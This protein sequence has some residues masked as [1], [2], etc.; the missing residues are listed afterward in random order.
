MRR[1][2]PVVVIGLDLGDGRLLER[3]GR[4]GALPHVR[5]LLDAGVATRLST[6]AEVLHVSA[7]PSLYTGA[8]PGEHGVY[9]TFQPRPGAQGHRRFETGLYGRPTVWRLLDRAGVRCSVLDAP[10]THPEPGDVA[11]VFDWGV[12]AQYLGPRSAPRTLLRRLRAAVGPYRLGLEAHDIGLAALD[13][14]EMSGR[15]AAAAGQKAEAALWTMRERPWDLFFVVFGETHPAA[16]YCWPSGADVDAAARASD[17]RSV[18]DAIDRGIGRIVE[19]APAD[20][21][22]CLVSADAAAP[23]H[24]AWHLLPEALRRLGWLAEPAAPGGPE[25]GDPGAPTGDRSGSAGASDEAPGRGTGR[26]GGPLRRLRDALP[27]DLRKSLAR[28]L[29]RALRDALARRVDTALID[30]SRTRA[31]CLPT[32][33]EGYV[34][35]NL[36]GREPEGI[37]PP[38]AYEDACDELSE[39]IGALEDPETGSPV[40]REVVR[41]RRRFPG[42]RSDFLPDLVVLW[43]D[44]AGPRGAIRHPDVGTVRGE[45]PDG[46]TATH[47]APGFLA[48]RPGRSDA[49]WDSIS[50]VRDVAPALLAHFDAATPDPPRGAGG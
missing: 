44:G 31:F 26:G 27:A 24:G 19:E 12:W 11:Q 18:Y 22:I 36:Q 42:P 41:V 28:R 6:S 20:A 48:A 16:H 10:Y 8:H 34:R 23:N 38:E 39:Q 3:W 5:G 21:T 7:W 45:T 37:V 50:D 17:L 47:A 2:P 14:T 9:Y 1:A 40:V 25:P 30:W 46:R 43:R 32:D 4:E 13:S 33:L 29:P 35:I 49:R 15:L